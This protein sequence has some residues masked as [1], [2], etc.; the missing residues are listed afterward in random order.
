M[1]RKIL[2]GLALL[3]FMA[4]AAVMAYPAISSYVNQLHGSYVI[5]SL[6]DR[7]SQAESGELAEQRC[8]AEA[9]NAQ[10]SGTGDGTAV[11]YYGILDYGDG[12]MGCI[13]IPEIG[14]SLPIYHGVGD[15]VL[16]KGVGHLP[17]SAFPIGGAGN[18]TVLTGHTGLPSA[19]LFTDLTKLEEGDVFYIQILEQTL[20][21]Q[22][23]R[24]RVVL[25]DEAAALC[26]VPGEDLCTLV[27]C[28]PYGVNSHRLL[29]TGIRM[30]DGAQLQICE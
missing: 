5:Q 14:V 26:P 3:L 9:Y 6:S 21:Y 29:V 16:A 30:T 19:K 27:T 24:I 17:Q 25:P 20:T 13:R 28:T 18:H 8:L 2:I 10:L 23:D 22:V 15:E 12:V 1:G 4:G 7:V 11:D